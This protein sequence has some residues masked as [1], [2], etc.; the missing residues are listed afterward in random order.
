MI[1][2]CTSGSTA[3]FRSGWVPMRAHLAAKPRGLPCRDKRRAKGGRGTGGE[4]GEGRRGG[5]GR[6]EEYAPSRTGLHFRYTKVRLLHVF[7]LWNL[8][9]CHHV[10]IHVPFATQWNG[11]LHAPSHCA[12]GMRMDCM[13]TCR[14]HVWKKLYPY[15]YHRATNRPRALDFSQRIKGLWVPQRERALWLRV[16][17]EIHKGINP[18]VVMILSRTELQGFFVYTSSLELTEIFQS[19]W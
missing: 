3:D 12:V 11:H 17:P 9:C 1:L 13:N 19:K 16:I 8:A 4:G 2:I 10:K 18:K 7:Y 6:G 14:T 15:P 5:G